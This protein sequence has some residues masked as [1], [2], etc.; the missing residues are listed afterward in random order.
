MADQYVKEAVGSQRHGVS[1][2]LRSEA[3]LLHL[4]RVTT[5]NCSKAS[6]QWIS[7][8]VR[9]ERRCRPPAGSGLRRKALRRVRKSLASRYYQ[10]LS[11]HAAIGSFLH[12]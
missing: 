11:G 3:S 2:E 10:F 6:A 8:H 12:K 9:P 1:N 7:T 5:E 4:T